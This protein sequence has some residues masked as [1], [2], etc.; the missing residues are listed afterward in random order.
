MFCVHFVIII[1]K[2]P[3]RS[4]FDTKSIVSNWLSKYVIWE[5]FSNAEIDNN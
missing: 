4:F 3:L 2:Q 5:Q 1:H